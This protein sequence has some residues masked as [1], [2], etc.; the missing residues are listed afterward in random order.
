[1][2]L[3]SMSDL[4]GQLIR[5]RLIEP[6]QL[7]TCLAD[8]PVSLDDSARLLEEL[9]KRSLLTSYQARQIVK[10]EIEGL[11]LGDYKLMYR[12]A[13][14]SFARVFR[15]CSL[16]DGRMVGLKLLRRRWANDPQIVSLFFHEAEVGKRLVHPNIVPIYSIETDRN[17]HFLTMEFIEGGN[18]RDFLAIRQKMSP[19]ESIRCALDICEGLNY[20]IRQ[21]ITHRDLK[22]TNVLMSSQGVAKLVDFGLAT[23]EGTQL[24]RSDSFQRALEYGT[25]EKGTNAPTN[26]PRSDLYFLGTILYELLTGIPPYPRTNDRDSRRQTSRYAN[27]R[28]IRTIDPNIARSVE[29]IVERLLKFDPKQRFQSAA[30]TIASLRYAL[31]DLGASPDRPNSSSSTVLSQPETVP[32]NSR[33]GPA[34]QS[35]SGTIMFVE[36]RGKL[37]E[38][39]RNHFNKHGFRVLVISDLRR[40]LARYKNN[41]PDCTII[42]SETIADDAESIAS[43]LGEISEN[44]PFAG[45][46]VFSSQHCHLQELFQNIP[47]LRLLEQPITL[48]RL[49]KVVDA[50]LESRTPG[51]DAANHRLL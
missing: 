22:L 43:E 8:L 46:I 19:I 7:E 2:S 33:S 24:A 5:H 29:D 12:N 26:D 28:P 16:K 41:P 35:T 37:Q 44:S 50:L 31:K 6:S 1:M 34:S 17:F 36:S 38:Q 11:I 3:I 18:L 20:A 4:G 49:R 27:I 39:L 40:G 23:I 42:L 9:E 48:G 25:L 47:Q 13:A 30:E 51:G 14:G 21:G 32:Q 10:G 15:A 45:V